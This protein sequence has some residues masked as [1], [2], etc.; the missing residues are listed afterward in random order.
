VATRVVVGTDGRFFTADF[1]R[2]VALD[3]LGIA[4]ELTPGGHL[5]ALRRPVELAD[6]LVS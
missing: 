1:Q 3:R 2:R 5:V 4:P 6:L